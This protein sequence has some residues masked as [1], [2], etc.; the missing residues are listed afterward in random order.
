M[1]EQTEI[2]NRERWDVMKGQLAI[3]PFFVA[4]FALTSWFDNENYD[5]EKLR[6]VNVASILVLLVLG[7]WPAYALL[8]KKFP[9]ER[10]SKVRFSICCFIGIMLTVLLVRPFMMVLISFVPSSIETDFE[11]FFQGIFLI[12]YVSAFA[13]I[14]G[15]IA[16]RL[17]KRHVNKQP[18]ISFVTGLFL[19]LLFLGSLFVLLHGILA[20][21]I[22]AALA[23]N[24][25]EHGSAKSQFYLAFSYY[26]KG[27][28]DSGVHRN[29]IEAMKW[30]GK[31]AAQNYAPAL[32]NLGAGYFEGEGVPQ[33]KAKAAE[34]FRKAAEQGYAPSQ[35][36]LALMLRSG[37]GLPRDETEGDTWLQKANAQDYQ[38][39]CASGT[40]I[41]REDEFH[42]ASRSCNPKR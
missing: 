19:V 34:L 28:S 26:D 29:P 42:I 27:R 25:A 8:R 13:V 40:D 33:D 20:S 31:A 32:N 18:M 9:N 23:I 15:Q 7:N 17:V 37:D 10:I 3:A 4:F 5:N 16:I 24:D 36:H 38:P 1:S 11:H 35:H 22:Y 30:Y 21:R 12:L 41:C 2:S 39:D 6:I 14:P